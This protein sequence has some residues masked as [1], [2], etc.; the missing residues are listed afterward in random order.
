VNPEEESP[1]LSRDCQAHCH[2]NRTLILFDQI[3]RTLSSTLDLD[4]VLSTLLDEVRSLLGVVACSVWLIDPETGGLVCRQA[5]GPKNDLVRG[6]HLAP[7]EGLAGWCAHRGESLIVPDVHAD[8]RYFS[9]VDQQTGLAL[10]SI[11]TVPLK[12]QE[13]VIGVLQAV[14]TTIDRFEAADLKLLE[15]VAA[16][17]AIAIENARLYTQAQEEIARRKQVEEA[18]RESEERFRTMADTAPV[19]LWMSGTDALCMFFNK[20]WLDF[21][22]RT[23]EEEVGNGWVEG[24][25]PDDREH[26]VETYQNAFEAHLDFRMEY[27][28]RR[29]D[30]EYRWVLDSGTPRFTPEGAFAGYIG[31]CLDITERKQAEDA[32]E[33][34]EARYRAVVENQTDLICRFLP[35]TTLTFVNE[36]YCDYFGKTRQELLGTSFL[37]LLPDEDQKTVKEHV[38]SLTENPGIV[39]Y[40][41]RAMLPDGTQAWQQWVDRAILDAQDRV[42]EFLSV[43][44]DITERKLAEQKLRRRAEE[45][46]TLQ[47]TVLDIT[48]R[49]NLPTLL[50]TIVRRAARL[51]RASGGGLYLCNP[52]R[53]KAQCVVSYNTHRDYT[54]TSLEYGDGAAGVVAQTKQPLIITDYQNWNGKASL[55]E[56]NQPFTAVLSAPMTWEGQVTGVL[57]VL[58]DEE[59]QTFTQSDMELLTL[60]ANHA[61]I[62]VENARLYEE[63]RT[64]R[65]RLQ[66]LSQRLVDAQEIERRRIARELHDEIGQTLTVVKI[67]LQTAQSLLEAPEHETQLAHSIDAVERTLQQ[68]R[69]LSLN[70]RPSLLDDLGLMPALRWYI[71]QQTQQASFSTS[72]E[73]DSLAERLPPEL[74]IVCFRIVQEALTNIIRH[75]EAEHV[76]I[77]VQKSDDQLKILIRDD[78]VGFN[79]QRAL[80]DASWGKSLGLMSMQERAAVVGGT[81]EIESEPGQGSEVS[82][83]FTLPLD[84]KSTGSED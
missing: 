6:W 40:E 42:V 8:D 41:H 46:D 62:A 48:A 20:P 61:A 63:L 19:M 65:E 2:P 22:G 17:A 55:F 39:S 9:E 81:V 68:V 35:D 44:R 1:S 16:S 21:R 31:S 73:A 76:D 47:A 43:G 69:D 56:D 14:D 53:G 64:G 32:L 49:H 28:L 71:D 82:A 34:S 5:T 30:G 72:F 84:E 54:G 24:V 25:H 58:H 50:E 18:L 13:Q 45:L 80:N 83:Y 75:A 52:D 38:V 77:K 60:F 37:E 26:C 70:L 57:Q 78:G 36:A 4:E 66:A 59:G 12:V 3:G 33:R 10:R 29:F 7:G 74:E 15:P 79:V 27:R 67:N 51:L 23:M 11:L